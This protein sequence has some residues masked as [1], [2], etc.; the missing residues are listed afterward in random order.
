M[1]GK[2]VR[3]SRDAHQDQPPLHLVSAWAQVNHLV[4][5]PQ[6][7]DHHTN[8]ITVIPKLW[9]MRD[10]AG[11]MVTLVRVPLGWGCQTRIAQQIWDQEADYLLAGKGNPQALQARIQDTFASRT[12]SR[13]RGRSPRRCGDGA[14]GPRP[15][16]N[17]PLRD[18]GST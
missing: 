17:L 13:L 16:R 11:C 9:Q 18:D 12:D 4:L 7:V 5:A 2:S 10:L 8:D 14:Q 1:D 6:A 3:G 15:G